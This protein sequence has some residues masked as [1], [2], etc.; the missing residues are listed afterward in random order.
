MYILMYIHRIALVSLRFAS[1]GF[2][3]QR[4]ELQASSCIST[5]SC[6]LAPPAR[7]S[8]TLKP[9][10]LWNVQRVPKSIPSS[11]NNLSINVYRSIQIPKTI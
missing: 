8:G 9:R 6:Q 3:L 7:T 11:Y 4:S 1:N 2:S 10:L 5:D